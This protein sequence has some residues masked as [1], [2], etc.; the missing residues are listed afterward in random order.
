M[1]N[2]LCQYDA[3]IYPVLSVTKLSDFFAL[4]FQC[5]FIMNDCNMWFVLDIINV[6]ICKTFFS[7]NFFITY[8]IFW[9]R[10]QIACM[11]SCTFRRYK[12]KVEIAGHAKIENKT[13]WVLFVM[14]HA[15]YYSKEMGQVGNRELFTEHFY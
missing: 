3:D 13:I 15:N 10:G 5:G 12:T 4:A 7:P 6:S 14:Y 9:L 8:N 11:L 1:N 2:C